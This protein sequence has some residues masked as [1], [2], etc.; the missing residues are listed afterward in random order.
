MFAGVLELRHKAISGLQPWMLLQRTWVDDSGLSDADLLLS[1]TASS[2]A[3][4]A[5]PSGMRTAQRAA[6]MA[7]VGTAPS[8][9]A[10]D[11]LPSRASSVSP[12]S[13]FRLSPQHKCLL[14]GRSEQLHCSCFLMRQAGV[15]CQ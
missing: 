12:P 6:P 7:A 14:Q 11:A 2:V 5:A 15:M 1:S 9:P 10:T 13:Q 8:A 3:S 4:L